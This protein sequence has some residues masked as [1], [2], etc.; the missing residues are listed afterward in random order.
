VNHRALV[1]FFAAN[2]PTLM[3]IRGIWERAGGRAGDLIVGSERAI[4]IWSDL[5]QRAEQGAVNPVALV[6]EAL[7]Q[8]PGNPE[9][10]KYLRSQASPE[11]LRAAE[12]IVLEL[13]RLDGG[14]SPESLLPRLKAFDGKPDEA[15]SALAL[16]LQGRLSEHKR[17]ALITKLQGWASV[18]AADL[19]S[20]GVGMLVE[21]IVKALTGTSGG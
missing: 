17:S 2:Y 11:S 10:L 15:F 16:S 12:S 3:A 4:D 6:R 8:F 5:W 18:I 7:I 19:R 20:A 9:L 1:E 13:E 14:S 21:Q